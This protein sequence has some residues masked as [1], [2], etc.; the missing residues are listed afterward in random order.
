L[1]VGLFGAPDRGTLTSALWLT[2]ELSLI[3]GLRLRPYACCE[4]ST[5][6]IPDEFSRR[7]QQRVS[8]AQGRGVGRVRLDAVADSGEHGVDFAQGSG[9]FA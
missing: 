5:S 1:W 7:S 9:D 8:A 2:S 4:R 6:T 3:A